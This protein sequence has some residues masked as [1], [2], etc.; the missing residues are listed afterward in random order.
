MPSS[1]PAASAWPCIATVEKLSAKGGTAM[2]VPEGVTF[3]KPYSSEEQR[4]VRV[5][6]M[7]GAGRGEEQEKRSKQSGRKESN[8]LDD[9]RKD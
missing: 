5:E 1:S 6:A 2:G 3:Q 7:F 9:A 4:P 8:A